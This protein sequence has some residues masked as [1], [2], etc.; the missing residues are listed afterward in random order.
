MYLFPQQLLAEKRG[1]PRSACPPHPLLLDFCTEEEAEVVEGLCPSRSCQVEQDE[2]LSSALCNR[3]DHVRLWFS[4]ANCV[5]C[6]FCGH[7]GA[8][9]V[10]LK[11]ES[12]PS[13]S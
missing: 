9:H 7:P 2:R 5:L 10:N 6:S 11:Q 8:P 12:S 4:K 13:S 3:E 1:H